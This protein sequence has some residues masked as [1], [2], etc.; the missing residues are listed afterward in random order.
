MALIE[1]KRTQQQ[2][3]TEIDEIHRL[4]SIGA[5]DEYIMQQR[6][7]SRTQFY[8]YKKRL[9]KQQSKIWEKKSE[10]QKIAEIQICKERLI[11]D[12]TN[13]ATKAQE[14]GANP[15]WGVYASELA[16]SILNLEMEGIRAVHNGKLR[17]LE[18]KAEYIRYSRPITTIQDSKRPS[19]GSGPTESTS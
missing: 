8:E 16:I 5:T 14:D 3:Q 10:D 19:T 9:V 4:W 6:G 17:Q 13:A 18:E 2:V 11:T 1:G 15:L 7:L 12:R